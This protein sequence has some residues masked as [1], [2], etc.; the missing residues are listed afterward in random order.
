MYAAPLLVVSYLPAYKVHIVL[1]FSS[2]GGDLILV[3]QYD[4]HD[5]MLG[6]S[7]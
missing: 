4:A 7:V 3:I 6:A 2:G 5:S 1:V